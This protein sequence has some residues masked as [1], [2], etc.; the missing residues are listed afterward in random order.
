MKNNNYFV[1]ELQWNL[2]GAGGK[3]L[4]QETTRFS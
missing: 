2:E 1:Y 3:K 4:A